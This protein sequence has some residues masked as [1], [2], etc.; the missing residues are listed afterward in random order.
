MLFK[1][2]DFGLFQLIGDVTGDDV[3]ENDFVDA[4]E[5]INDDVMGNGAADGDDDDNIDDDLNDSESV[6]VVVIVTAVV[7]DDD[8]RIFTSVVDLVD[9]TD[10]VENFLVVSSFA[11]HP[12]CVEKIK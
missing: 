4:T 9:V 11:F 8:K 3:V 2:K 1:S 5:D 10:D 7:G 12:S 6:L